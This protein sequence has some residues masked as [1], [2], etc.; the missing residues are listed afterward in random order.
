MIFL[1]I[2]FKLPKQRVCENV[3]AERLREE[4]VSDGQRSVQHLEDTMLKV[5]IAD[6]EL[7]I[8]RLLESL[9]DWEAE[10]FTIEGFANNGYEAANLCIAIKPDLLITDIRMPGLGGLELV[11]QLHKQMPSIH[12]IIITGYSQFQYAHQALRY[13]VVDY[14]LKP[15]RTD[16]LLAA[17]NNVKERVQYSIAPDLQKSEQQITVKTM[18]TIKENLLL[19]LLS[20]N[21]EFSSMGKRVDIPEEVHIDYRGDSWRL[22]QIEII[23]D[24]THDNLSAEEYLGKKIHEIISEEFKD[25]KLE[26]IFV[27]TG[28]GYFCLVNGEEDSFLTF[29]A[30]LQ[31]VK[32]ILMQILELFKGTFTIGVSS[33]CKTLHNVGN[34]VGECETAVNHKIIAGKNQVICYSDIPVSDHKQEEFIS[35]YW[36]KEFRKAI[37]DADHKAVANCISDLISSLNLMS[38]QISGT[39]VNEVYK[40]LIDLFF[41]SILVFGSENLEKYSKEELVSQGKFFYSI[42]AAFTYLSNL[43][44][45]I[46]SN[47]A[48]EKGEQSTRPIRMAQ[49][50]VEEHYTEAVKLQE[51]AEYVG[52]APSYLSSLFKKQV[53][54]SLVE[55]LTYIRIQNAKQLLIDRNRNIADIADEVGFV[56][57]KYFIK[58]FKKVTGLTP[59]EYRKLFGNG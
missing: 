53:K 58:R 37:A 31:N 8:C 24:S 42:T 41:G 35:E 28:Q 22:V 55:Y 11:Q 9:I 48:E 7:H 1:Y 2:S 29:I 43:F 15:I 59:N 52:L 34:C 19:S 4:R 13:G 56:D 17:L 39:F 6:D 36:E 44:R 40:E 49:L 47:L 23:L 5:I 54:K 12:A 18:Q 21:A 45:T 33:L 38:K 30:H 51:V 25:E 26:L 57:E 20:G 46:I 10:G 3:C 14:L 27:R 16:E 32:F 50:Y